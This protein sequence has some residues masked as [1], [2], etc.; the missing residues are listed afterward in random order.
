MAIARVRERVRMGGHDIPEE[1][2]RRRY[3][4]GIRNFFNLYRPRADHWFF[5]DN[6]AIYSPRLIAEGTRG[7][8]E[9]VHDPEIW[10]LV[11]GAV[12]DARC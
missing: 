9:E 8:A 10:S 12:R 2:I 5:Y 4:G 1:V 7:S 6:T 3:E 11:L